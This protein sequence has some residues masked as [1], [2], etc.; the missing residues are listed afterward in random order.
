MTYC[1]ALKLNA[2]LVFT[3]DSRT[4]AGVDQIACFKK[5]RS[6]V[7]VDD[8]VIVILS[9]GNL[10]ITQNAINLLEQHGRHA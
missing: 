5:M 7:N 9:S 10:S 2:G 8:R 3:S 4:N 6:F 1:V